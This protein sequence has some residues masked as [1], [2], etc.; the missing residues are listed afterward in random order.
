MSSSM[1]VTLRKITEDNLYTI[2][3]LKVTPAQENFVA[4]NA[5]SL[6]EALF[7]QDV[8]WFRAIYADDVPVGFVML[9]DDPTIPLYELWRFMVDANFQQQGI[10]RR[11]ITLVANYV[12][13]RPNARF[14]LTSCVEGEGSPAQFYEKVGFISTGEKDEDGELIM[15]LKLADAVTT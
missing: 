1:S 15:K 2:L 13:T 10:G 5:E 8:A 9:V 12:R 14:L 7:H 3:D 4:S 6:A 11:A